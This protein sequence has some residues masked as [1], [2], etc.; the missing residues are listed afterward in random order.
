MGYETHVNGKLVSTGGS[1]WWSNNW[2]YAHI[3]KLTVN[4]VKGKAMDIRI[5]GGEL[6]CDGNHNIRF[7]LGGTGAY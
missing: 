5:Y 6:C 1:V 4:L 7:R 3:H 2:N